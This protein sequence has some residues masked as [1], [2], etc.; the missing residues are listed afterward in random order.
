MKTPNPKAAQTS[1]TPIFPQT[2]HRVRTRLKEGVTT[3]KPPQR[4]NVFSKSR[5]TREDRG[6]R[7]VKMS[8]SPQTFPHAR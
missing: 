2:L 7:Q 5:D 3:P 4:D 1:E 6:A 8:Q